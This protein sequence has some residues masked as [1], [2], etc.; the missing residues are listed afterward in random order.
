MRY[1]QEHWNQ[2]ALNSI[3]LKS[4]LVLGYLIAFNAYIWLL[5]VSAPSK[6]ATYACVNSVIAVLLEWALASE[7]ITMGTL[8]AAAV[9]IVSVV[10]ITGHQ[11]K[12]KHA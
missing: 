3:E 10:I 4:I 6:V 9:I 11:A 8:A 5:G 2:A 1:T 12:S 7:T